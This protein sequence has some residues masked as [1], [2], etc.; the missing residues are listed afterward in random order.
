MQAIWIVW[1]YDDGIR[2]ESSV[3]DVFTD[4]KEANKCAATMNSN[5][6]GFYYEVEKFY[7]H[8]KFVPD[9]DE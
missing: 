2:P 6:N 1:E 9:N 3:Y 4:E 7:A 5:Q 8:S